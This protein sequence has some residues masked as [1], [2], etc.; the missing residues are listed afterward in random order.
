MTNL[1]PPPTPTNTATPTPTPSLAQVWNT[2]GRGVKLRQSPN[3]PVIGTLQEGSYVQV[4]YGSEVVEGL[5][6]LEVVGGEGRHGW[7]PQIYLTVVTLT[8]TATAGQ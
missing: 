1:L 2:G 7:M 3:G 8:P 4:L 6:W 5:V